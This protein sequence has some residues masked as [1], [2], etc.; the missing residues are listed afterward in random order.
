MFGVFCIRAQIRR[1]QDDWVV[2]LKLQ[3]LNHGA[4]RE[5]N[6][7]DLQWVEHKD[8]V[9][10]F[11]SMASIR[12]EN[13]V[14]LV[15][16]GVA[17]ALGLVWAQLDFCEGGEL[18]DR[19][20]KIDERGA[21]NEMNQWRW[22]CGCVEGLFALH[23]AN[24]IHRDIKPANI[25]LTS[26]NDDDARAKLADFGLARGVS[27]SDY[28]LASSRASRCGTP[29]YMAPEMLAGKAYANRTDVF[30]L[31][32]VFLEMV[33][34]GKELNGSWRSKTDAVLFDPLPRGR[35]K[36]VA[37]AAFKR[38]PEQRPTAKTLRALTHQLSGETTTNS[39]GRRAFFAYISISPPPAVLAVGRMQSRLVFARIMHKFERH[40]REQAGDFFEQKGFPI[41]LGDRGQE[42]FTAD[43]LTCDISTMVWCSVGWGLEDTS[44][45]QLRGLIS[46]LKATSKPPS[47]LI[48]CMKHGARSAALQII[49]ALPN[50]NTVVWLQADVLDARVGDQIFGRVVLPVLRK[51]QTSSGAYSH[52]L[53]EFMRK[54]LLRFQMCSTPAG[55][56]RNNGAE[57]CSPWRPI[58]CAMI[59]LD[60]LTTNINV[61][62][63]GDSNLHLVDSSLNR[64]ELLST[65][66]EWCDQ[67][68]SSVLK[69]S[70]H[71]NYS[72][73]GE[74]GRAIT[75]DVCLSILSEEYRP[76][77]Q[78]VFR[79]SS[80]DD[81]RILK[82]ILHDEPSVRRVLVWFDIIGQYGCDD[83]CTITSKKSSPSGQRQASWLES[84]KQLLSESA[85]KIKGLI[86]RG[87][88]SCDDLANS[89]AEELDATGLG[90]G[91]ND[92]PA[93]EVRADDLYREIRMVV[94][95]GGA[96]TIRNSMLL[97]QRKLGD[98]RL[99]VGITP[100]AVYEDEDRFLLQVLLSDISCVD[101]LQQLVISGNL[102]RILEL[103]LTKHL[104]WN[105]SAQS[106]DGTLDVAWAVVP[107]SVLHEISP[108]AITCDV[109]SSSGCA[110]L[111]PKRE[112]RD[113]ADAVKRA[114]QAGAA[115]AIVVNDD[116]E[117]PDSN[118]VD[119]AHGCKFDNPV[120]FLSHNDGNQVRALLH[121]GSCTCRVLLSS[122]C[123]GNVTFNGFV[124][125]GRSKDYVLTH[126]MQGVGSC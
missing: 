98:W 41:F 6:N 95:A 1:R 18:A 105:P 11:E 102:E 118:A 50:V 30:S 108:A 120:L 90:D 54:Q 9:A 97:G 13:I 86:T 29:A 109:L 125:C 49:G 36:E 10:E 113:V 63:L 39:R 91:G 42:S 104:C 26:R 107:C 123:L 8:A 17:E 126:S 78:L 93:N 16:Y 103:E 114:H 122:A 46:A 24:M 3:A 55:V 43:L 32:L 75:L 15:Q 34:G 82:D 74:R 53:E 28:L 57:E 52:R 23:K 85:P 51:I 31:A 62:P 21:V 68:K 94:Q 69:A 59:P 25:L 67:L 116:T 65:D 96:H 70:D 22:M 121:A 99:P 80:P 4:R 88:P 79:A 44:N 48:V 100:T 84:L 73:F 35:G 72:I 112:G 111:L 56:L 119:L 81:L 20:K 7:L 64:L 71:T 2:C 110:V 47:A 77:F 33:S 40:L 117:N 38:D 83:G 89:I 106:S 92:A 58:N 37:L 14:N 115:T 87:G 5:L 27:G 61:L 45:L 12:H 124:S 19:Y 66:M 76:V 60:W 101:R